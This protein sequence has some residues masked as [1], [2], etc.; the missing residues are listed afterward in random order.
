MA[1]MEEY[2]VIIVGAGPA[3]SS[4]A[5]FNAKAGK[6]VLL[7]DKASF[8][9]DK[10]C[11][12]GVTGKS[13]TILDEMGLGDEINGIKEISSTGVLI[14]APNQKELRIDI[15]SPEDPFSAFSIEREIFDNIIF[16]KAREMIQSNGGTFKQEKVLKPI[17]E[18]GI[19]VGVQTKENHYKAKLVIGA[20][21][22]NCPISRTVL[23]HNETP[24]QERK[25]Y[26][27]AIREYWHDIEGNS[28]DFEIHFIDGILPGYFWIFPISENRFNIGV[29]MLL[30]DMDNQSVKLKEMLS[31]IV[32][33]S[34]LSKRFK[35]AKK[36]EKTLKGWLLPLGSPRGKGLHPR[37]NFMNGCI[38]IGDAA[39]LIDPFTGEGIGNALTSGKLTA[40]YEIIDDNTGVEYQNELWSLIGE[41]LH[42][43]HRLQ[44][45]LKKK[46]LV[47]WFVNKANKKP[48]LQILL[49]DMLH[50]KETQ[51]KFNSKWFLLKSLLF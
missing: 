3:G 10:I 8:P 44:K 27:S 37:K 2:D 21:G 15:A 23:N 14:V 5:Y 41:E 40:N 12:D 28:G 6:K 48:K 13:L 11:G 1:W 34:Y 22:Y 17:I 29:G 42:N 19:M 4:S 49:T 18:D 30:D 39:S 47:N 50:N 26:S 46:W 24:K 31:Y 7:L 45:M 9:R 51:D 35:N 38:L 36:E 20:G 33:E 16:Q 25:H 43:S 32:N